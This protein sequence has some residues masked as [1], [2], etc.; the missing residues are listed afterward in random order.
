M[1]PVAKVVTRVVALL[2]LLRLMAL[3]TPL[4]EK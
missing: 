2:L 4:Q 1:V 3:P